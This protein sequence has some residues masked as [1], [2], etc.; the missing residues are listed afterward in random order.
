MP[1]WSQEYGG[2]LRDDQIQDLTNFVMNWQGPQPPGVRQEGVEVVPTEAPVDVEATPEAPEEPAGAGDAAAGEQ[3]FA[4]YC[5]SCHGPG[6]E[7]GALGPSLISADVTA[8]DD[9][10]Y[11]ETIKNGRAGTAMP[12]WAGTLSPQDIENVIAWLRSKQ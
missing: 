4:T 11:R 8:K 6:A 12:A 2:P 3:T 9:D 1:S 7:G 10:Y 5:V